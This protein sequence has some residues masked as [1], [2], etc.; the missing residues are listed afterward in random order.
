MILTL[1]PSFR[2]SCSVG[3]RP[4]EMVAAGAQSVPPQAPDRGFGL[5]ARRM[6]SR[7]GETGTQDS[8]LPPLKSLHQEHAKP[9]QTFEPGEAQLG[10][11]PRGGKGAGKAGGVHL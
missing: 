4:A 8:C 7:T 9:V 11:T 3:E 5:L 2:L 6:M 1:G 10:G